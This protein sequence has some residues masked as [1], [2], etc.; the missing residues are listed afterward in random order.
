MR[1]TQVLMLSLAAVGLT[2]GVAGGTHSPG[3][4]PKHNF[5]HG[6][7]HGQQELPGLG[8]SSVDVHVNA[9]ADRD[10]VRARGHFII[11]L[12]ALEEVGSPGVEISGEVTCLIAAGSRA[13][14]GGEIERSNFAAF[15]EGSGVLI[16]IV[17]ND[18]PGSTAP[19]E[20]VTFAAPPPG[21]ACPPP[22]PAG[23]PIHQGNFVVHD[24]TED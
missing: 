19:D 22:V 13:M 23:E 9:N 18:Q 11:R 14:A 2:A 16:T 21:E 4:G 12:R 20:F 7:G 6:T 3:E 8:T 15:P 17:D 1:V 10:A 24:A 5:V